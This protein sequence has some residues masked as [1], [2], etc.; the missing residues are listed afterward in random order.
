MVMVPEW[1]FTWP[2]LSPGANLK[3]FK[4]PISQYTACQKST[5][6]EF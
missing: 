5:F 4:V 3:G 1:N 2:L 6:K